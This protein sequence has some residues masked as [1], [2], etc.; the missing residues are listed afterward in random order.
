MSSGSMSFSMS[1]S[2]FTKLSRN[3]KNRKKA[4]AEN[5]R[6]LLESEDQFEAAGTNR[7]DD[8]ETRAKSQ[9]FV[10]AKGQI[11]A[12]LDAELR[13]GFNDAELYYSAPLPFGLARD[14][15]STRCVHCAPHT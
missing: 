13:R 12:A 6:V 15:Y 10:V 14:T 11:P 8:S 1:S 2:S 5:P 4:V 7:G 3:G 9:L